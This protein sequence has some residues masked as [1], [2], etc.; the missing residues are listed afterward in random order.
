MTIEE[1]VIKT[2]CQ[3]RYS[4]DVVMMDHKARL[5]NEPRATCAEHGLLLPTCQDL[6]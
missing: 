3:T 6:V 4:K 1:E 2:V 5:Q